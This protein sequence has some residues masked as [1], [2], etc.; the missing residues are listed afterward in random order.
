VSRVWRASIIVTTYQRPR[1]LARVLASLQQ[2]TQAAHEV[3]IADDGSD[4][5]TAAVVRE[6]QQR[7]PV[8][9]HH[10]WQEDLGFRAAAAR[11]RAVAAASG[12][13]LI[14]LDGDCLV[15][16][17]FVAQH[18]SQA[19]AGMLVMG[20]RILAAPA[21]TEAIE[22]GGSDPLRWHWREWWRA[23]R[24]GDVNRLF[25]LIRLPGRYWR[26]RRPQRWQGVRTFNLAVW[27]SDFE[28]VNGFDES[29]LGWGHEDAD[30]AVRLMH[31]GVRRKDGQFALPVLHLWHR[32][33]SRKLEPENQARLAQ[34]V[35]DAAFIHA[36][37]GLDRYSGPEPAT[38]R[39]AAT[40]TPSPGI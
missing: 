2:Q 14:F 28:R 26:C 40:A 31:A 17:D 6:W 39:M 24:R 9:V 33:S 19:E 36:A 13:Y 32:E 21:L 23:Q 10:V 20:S 7:L 30:L 5:E 15:F 38:V 8:P 34:R 25:P 29:F 4:D 16:P 1:A 18:E 27:R 35:E 22:A 37:V 12:N 11:N 3:V